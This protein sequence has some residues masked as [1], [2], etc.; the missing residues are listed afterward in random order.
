MPPLLACS[1]PPHSP[2]PPVPPISS[3]LSFDPSTNCW[4]L[5]D[6]SFLPFSSLSPVTSTLGLLYLW[7]TSPNLPETSKSLVVCNPLTRSYRVLPQLGSAWSKHG[8]VLSGSRNCIAVLT[9]LAT[10]YFNGSSSVSKH[11]MKFS[12]NLP[13]KPRRPVIVDDSVFALCALG[14]T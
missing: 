1:C 13:S 5:L 14:H 4:I 11:W 10:L 6:L 3:L 9:E 8:S 7:A 12:S 2:S